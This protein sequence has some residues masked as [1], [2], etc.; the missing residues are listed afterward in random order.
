MKFRV[1]EDDIVKVLV[2]FLD[3]LQIEAAESDDIILSE[4]LNDVITELISSDH[5][6]D[7]EKE[8]LDYMNK[9]DDPN[10]NNQKFMEELNEEYKGDRYYEEYFKKLIKFI[11][12]NPINNIEDIKN[13]NNYFRKLHKNLGGDDKDTKKDDKKNT[14]N[15]KESKDEINKNAPD[16][17]IP[18]TK[19]EI[20]KEKFNLF[21]SKR[22]DRIDFENSKSLSKMISDIGIILPPK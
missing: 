6:F 10:V 22:K 3:E 5:I 12:S 16:D 4:F 20:N 21:Y 11:N 9:L 17:E 8:A 7:D 2:N 19:A 1:I 14:K 15:K 13:V 18:L